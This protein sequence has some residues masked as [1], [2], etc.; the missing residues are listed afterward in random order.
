MNT[1][2]MMF[3]FLQEVKRAALHELI[4]FVQT[5]GSSS[6]ST[7]SGQ[8]ISSANNK[9]NKDDNSSGGNKD[10]SSSQDQTPVLSASFEQTFYEEMVNTVCT[11]LCLMVM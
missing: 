4:E 3:I 11:A 6:T 8:S 5:S 7:T 10:Q 9:Q 2:L 1:A